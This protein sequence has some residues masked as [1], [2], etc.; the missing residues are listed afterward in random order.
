MICA[1]SFHETRTTGT[2]SVWQT[3]CSIGATS[4]IS[5]SPCCRSTHS[6]SKPWRAITSAVKPC[7]IDS[8]P[9]VTHLPSRHISLIL[10]LRMVAL[11]LWILDGPSNRQMTRSATAAFC[12]SVSAT[13]FRVAA[14]T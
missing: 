9:S 5:F 11:S 14:S 13:P 6:A 4:F 3:A 2:V 12:L 10:F 1:G 7:E 8:Q